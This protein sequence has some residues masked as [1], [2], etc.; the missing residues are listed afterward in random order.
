MRHGVFVNGDRGLPGI[1]RLQ[2][3]KLAL[4]DEARNSAGRDALGMVPPRS[5]YERPI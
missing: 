2:A 3:S 1:T 5:R 4:L